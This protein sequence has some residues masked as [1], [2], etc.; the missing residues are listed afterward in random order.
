MSDYDYVDS[1][2]A[3]AALLQKRGHKLLKRNR[4]WA[5]CCFAH[6][7]KT[8]SLFIADGKTR[9]IIN[10]RAGCDWN[11]IKF[12]LERQ[13][14][15]LGTAPGGQKPSNRPPP[16]KAPVVSLIPPRPPRIDQVLSERSIR[17]PDLL[18]PDIVYTY[19]DATDIAIG[20]ICRWNKNK[21]REKIVLPFSWTG[22]DWQW[23]AMPPLRPL[24]NLPEIILNTEKDIIFVE[25]EKAAD[26]IRHLLPQRIPTTIAGGSSSA[27][28]TDFAAL[29]GR[30]V[31][32]W[33]DYDK[34]GYK[35][36]IQ[37]AKKAHDAGAIDIRLLLWPAEFKVVHDKAVRVPTAP[38]IKGH[39]AAN[40]IEDGWNIDQFQ[41]M[42]RNH[43]QIRP[44]NFLE[45]NQ[46]K[47]SA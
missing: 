16:T 10:C 45:P 12:E 30:R 2:D 33:P 44:I 13:N 47:S 9:V 25:G 24:Y 27:D 42:L 15:R 18:Q 37:V 36:A 19:K 1:A 43:V 39:D 38:N 41:W 32:I 4:E 14:I 11:A 31:T 3:L 6:N 28:L 21:S 46:N 22:H 34:A 26:A 29:K 23:N 17:H 40:L 20:R 5:L 8:P 35:A 7:D